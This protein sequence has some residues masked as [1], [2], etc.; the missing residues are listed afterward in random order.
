MAFSTLKFYNPITHTYECLSSKPDLRSYSEFDTRKMYFEGNGL[1]D[2][3]QTVIKNSPRLTGWLLLDEKLE[4]A[5]CQNTIHNSK[6]LAVLMKLILVNHPEFLNFRILENFYDKYF[7][8]GKLLYPGRP[9]NENL[10][11]FLN[12]SELDPILKTRVNIVISILDYGIFDE[13]IT[14]VQAFVVILR[15]TNK[16]LYFSPDNNLGIIGQLLYSL[17]TEKLHIQGQKGF[18]NFVHLI[19]NNKYEVLDSSLS[20]LQAYENF[21]NELQNKRG[22]VDFKSIQGQAKVNIHESEIFNVHEYR[23]HLLD[24]INMI[25]SNVDKLEKNISNVRNIFLRID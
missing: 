18:S 24:L 5:I 23:A 9:Y 21:L 1:M 20:F 2:S 7:A 10:E 15:Q 6:R 19:T 4:K 22:I 13:R 8:S 14:P 25:H 12:I 16:F 11:L 3:F 17:F